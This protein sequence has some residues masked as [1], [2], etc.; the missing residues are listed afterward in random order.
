MF[1]TFLRLNGPS[2]TMHSGEVSGPVGSGHEVVPTDV[3]SEIQRQKPLEHRIF[4]P[5]FLSGC[6]GEDSGTSNLSGLRV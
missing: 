5:V 3:A 4:G 2:P 1:Y 6:F